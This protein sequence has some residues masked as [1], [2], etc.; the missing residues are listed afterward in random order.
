MPVIANPL[1]GLTVG[2]WNGGVYAVSFTGIVRNIIPSG[3]ISGGASGLVYDA[4]GNLYIDNYNT[5]IEKWDGTNPPT[6]FATGISL[7]YQMVLHNGTI[8]VT[9]NSGNV[10]SVNASTGGTA[11]V[12]LPQ[13]VGFKDL[14]GIGVDMFGDLIVADYGNYG[15]FR[16]DP[17]GHVTAL[18]PPSTSPMILPN[19]I[20]IPPSQLIYTVEEG[21]TGSKMWV[22]AP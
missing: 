4:S 14:E 6:S 11:S 19:G 5:S 9:S 16:I 18:V 8:Y 12:Y 17:Q 13:S 15:L 21:S 22:I 3:S 20:A 1:G 7:G 10:F 2:S